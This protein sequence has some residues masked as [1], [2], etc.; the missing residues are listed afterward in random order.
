MIQ[1]LNAKS[2]LK[3]KPLKKTMDYDF[4]RSKGIE[5]ITELSGRLWTDHNSHDPGITFMEMIC[6]ALTDLSYRTNFPVKDLM[7]LSEDEEQAWAT[8][9]TD[10]KDPKTNYNSF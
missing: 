5:F 3:N 10:P 2:I 6:Y 8:K 9:Y 4:L 1:N 7:A